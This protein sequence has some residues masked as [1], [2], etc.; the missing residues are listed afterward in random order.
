MPDKR[1]DLGVAVGVAVGVRGAT[2]RLFHS[3]PTAAKALTRPEDL[4]VLPCRA[5]DRETDA[6]GNASF[7]LIGGCLWK[8]LTIPLHVTVVVNRRAAVRK[9]VA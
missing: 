5:H 9:L 7:V 3:T 4:R 1:D 2:N 6:V 8:G